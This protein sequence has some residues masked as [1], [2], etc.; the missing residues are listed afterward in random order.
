[1]KMKELQ[2]A[3]GISEELNKLFNQIVLRTKR[4]QA[5]LAHKIIDNFKWLFIIPEPIME[6]LIA[7]IKQE[8]CD[9]EEEN[10]ARDIIIKLLEAFIPVKKFMDKELAEVDL[11]ERVGGFDDQKDVGYELKQILD[12][13]EKKDGGRN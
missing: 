2:D 9:I 5:F 8:K 6:Q 1:M 12:N 10:E 11:G 3:S 4:G 7:N 13:S